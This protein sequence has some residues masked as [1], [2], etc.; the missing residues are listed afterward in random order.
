MSS[1]AGGIFPYDHQFPIPIAPQHSTFE[2]TVMIS[3]TEFGPDHPDSNELLPARMLNEF[4]YCPRL[5]YLEHVAGLFQHNADTLDGS[6]RHRRVDRK[7]DELK[8][9]DDANERETIHARSVTLS[10]PR[11]GIV[12]KL[13]LVEATGNI[14][15]PVDYK[16]GSPRKLDD[17]T[18]VPWDPERVQ[19]CAQALVLRDNGYQCDEGIIFFWTTRQ[20]VRVPIDDELVRL[21]EQAIEGALQIKQTGTVPPPLVD[22]PKCPRCSLVSI[23][24]PDETN[25]CRQIQAKESGQRLIQ[26]LLFDTGQSINVG[27][28]PLGDM[29]P[30]TSDPRLLL[31]P[32]D[33]QKPV[34]LNTQGAYVGVSGQVLKISEKKKVIQEIRL[35]DISQVN[36]FGSVQ[37]TTQAIQRLIQAEIPLAFFTY[38]GWFYGMTQSI[39][40][41]NIVWRREQFRKADDPRFCLRLARWLVAGKITNQ[42]TLLMRNHVEPPRAALAYLKSLAFEAERATDLE[43][44]L[45]LEGIAA[46]T[47]FE[48]F[49]GMIKVP[50]QTD[51]LAGDDDATGDLPPESLPSKDANRSP[52]QFDF[53]GRNRRPPTDPINALL[54]LGYSL[55]T[56]DLTI[57]AMATGLDPYMGFYHQIR[58]GRPALSL[59]LMEPFRPLIVDSVVLSAINQR[60]VTLDDF[61]AAGGAVNLTTDGRKGFFRAYENRM[62]QLVTHPLFD[63]RVS[64]RRMLEIQT[65]LLARVLNGEIWEYPVF[66]TR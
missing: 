10:S 27:I 47:Y 45:G 24:L 49:Q 60:M 20:R 25:H 23:C 18:L 62:Q 16:R 2:G 8:H 58:A 31:T 65:R 64:Y 5:F 37:V 42:R 17:G 12:A 9:G 44:L 29:Q 21:T 40:Q 53:R 57:A 33:D 30:S 28:D 54:S 4:V 22:S 32:R 43:Q 61:I 1:P 6:R 63:Y 11:Y 59:D 39:L 7:T 34:Y 3:Q 55:L 19:I 38:G 51:P 48:H 56:K 66:T 35:R 46:K 52:F 13:D 15:T 36:L 26:P 14:A 41:K 50:P